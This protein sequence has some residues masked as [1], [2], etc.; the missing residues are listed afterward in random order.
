MHNLRFLILA[1]FAF[2]LCA[3][4]IAAEPP[5][6]SGIWQ[7]GQNITEPRPK[8]SKFMK[9]VQGGF[10]VLPTAAAYR[11]EI[12]I[13]S[14]LSTPYFMQALFE[15]PA[16]RSKPFV[17]ESTIAKPQKILTLTHGPVKGLHIVGDYRITVKIFRRK[18]DTEPLDIL[19]QKIRSYLD[20]TGPAIKMKGGMKSR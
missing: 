14:D 15:N 10:L 13:S 5:L 1:L 9:V 7:K 2:L 6:V 3:P 4:T 20:S 19:E 11:L 12:E 18:G 16:D 17:E 8:S